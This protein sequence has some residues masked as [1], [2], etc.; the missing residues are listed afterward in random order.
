[1]SEQI[2]VTV[3]ADGGTKVEVKGCAGKQCGELTKALEAA[4]GTVTQDVKKPEFYQPAKQ[5]QQQK[6]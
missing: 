3:A 4:L 1:V 2:E 5:T 6:A